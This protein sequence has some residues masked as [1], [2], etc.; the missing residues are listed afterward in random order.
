[1]N[2]RTPTDAAASGGTVPIQSAAI[3]SAPD[4]LEAL[5][6]CQVLASDAVTF[7][8]GCQS[9]PTQPTVK[10]QEC[11]GT[12][13]ASP[14]AGGR[15]SIHCIRISHADDPREY[16]QLQHI[17]LEVRRWRGQWLGFG[18]RPSQLRLVVEGAA[19]PR[20]LIHALT[21]TQC[22]SQTVTRPPDLHAAML[23][24]HRAPRR[25]DPL[26][27]PWSSHR[28]LM[29]LRSAVFF[30]AI[31]VTKRLQDLAALHTALGGRPRRRNPRVR[32]S[33]RE[34]W[35]V[36]AEAMGVEPGHRATFGLYVQLGQQ[37]GRTVRE[38]SDDLLLTQRRVRQLIHA[39]VRG[40]KA[41]NRLIQSGYVV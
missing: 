21:D 25:R 37:H 3:N 33:T 27:S 36:S 26:A 1:M 35:H 6:V 2:R 18:L 38:L 14:R 29:G 13:C 9:T 5:H 23:W 41:A 15:L 16:P 10:R 31:P 11:T 4:Q 17:A 22:A 20:A 39:E 7:V 8:D 24:A 19:C 32:L 12:A 34:I 30:D 28:D 40:L